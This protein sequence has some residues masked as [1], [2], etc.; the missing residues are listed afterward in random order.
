MVGGERP[1]CCEGFG[2]SPLLIHK[3]WPRSPSS[4]LYQHGIV[5]TG[6]RCALADPWGGLGSFGWTASSW[7]LR[8]GPQQATRKKWLWCLDARNAYVH[9]IENSISDSST[10]TNN[11]IEKGGCVELCVLFLPLFAIVTTLSAKHFYTLEIEIIARLSQTLLAVNLDD[12]S[13]LIR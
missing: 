8:E 12:E 10:D 1:R 4:A 9:S 7:W 5:I 3:R 6:G 2:P 13:R 11:T